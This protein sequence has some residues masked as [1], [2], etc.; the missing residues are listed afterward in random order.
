MG[1]YSDKQRI[2][3]MYTELINE[4][5]NRII[6]P[7]E[8]LHHRHT[9]KGYTQQYTVKMPVDPSGFELLTTNVCHCVQQDDI[10]EHIKKFDPEIILMPHSIYYLKPEMINKILARGIVI[11]FVMHVFDPNQTKGSIQSHQLVNE[12][13][14][15]IIESKTDPSME[16]LKIVRKVPKIKGVTIAEWWRTGGKINFEVKDDK[17]YIHND[18]M[19]FFFRNSLE[20]DSTGINQI[21]YRIKHGGCHHISGV[22]KGALIPKTVQLGASEPLVLSRFTRLNEAIAVTKQDAISYIDG[23]NNEKILVQ[24]I[25]GKK[26]II[27]FNVGSLSQSLALKFKKWFTLDKEPQTNIMAS[28]YY[29]FMTGF[30][31][32]LPGQ[33]L[34]VETAT[35]NSLVDAAENVDFTNYDDVD[36]FRQMVCRFFHNTVTT[37]LTIRTLTFQI[38]KDVAFNKL[39]T[40][41]LSQS[42]FVQC[43]KS[44][45]KVGNELNIFQQLF[46]K[47]SDKK[48]DTNFNLIKKDKD[49]KNDSFS[50]P[51]PVQT[52]KSNIKLNPPVQLVTVGLLEDCKVRKANMEKIAE[53]IPIVVKSI[54]FARL[55]NRLM[56]RVPKGLGMMEKEPD[57]ELVQKERHCADI[58][59]R[60]QRTMKQNIK[61]IR[62][63]EQDRFSMEYNKL[64][65]ARDDL[66][67]ELRDT[68]GLDEETDILEETEEF[69]K[70]R[71]SK[72]TIVLPPPPPVPN[73]K[74]TT[75]DPELTGKNRKLYKKDEF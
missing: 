26:T 22:L 66:K 42:N 61:M 32:E 64:K 65:K 40:K 38:L 27:H 48:V 23:E 6:E 11:I 50:Q 25:E 45:F 19:N 4:I 72:P 5:N 44:V 75:Y 46:A 9:T 3:K 60:I 29:D 16:P 2:G 36:T 12:E 13:V 33:K 15:K 30:S 34:V 18:C 20:E 53:K 62:E 68:Q 28:D 54:I 39:I 21:F 49:S 41:E 24:D 71:M 67:Y 47:F 7:S 51:Q 56:D 55:M 14:V 74:Y 10:C 73:M 43:F 57:P 70:P 31:M 17:K 63:A 37:P 52:V 59:E 35:Y 58:N 1:D 69:L 8:E